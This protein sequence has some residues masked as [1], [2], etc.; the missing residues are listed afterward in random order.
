[1]EKLLAAIGGNPNWSGGV[2][3]PLLIS[4]DIRRSATRPLPTSCTP[5]TECDLTVLRLWTS[6]RVCGTSGSFTDGFKVDPVH[7]SLFLFQ[8]SEHTKNRSKS[9]FF[10]LNPKVLQDLHASG[11]VV[12]SD[13]SAL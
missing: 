6:Q 1:M 11:F 5:A 12:R 10:C 3:L 8:S 9:E 4:L 7:R 2:Y 13:D